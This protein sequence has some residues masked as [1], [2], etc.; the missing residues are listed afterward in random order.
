MKP[1]ITS[2]LL[3]LL[4]FVLKIRYCL[5]DLDGI[6]SGNEC[7]WCLT[8]H[9]IQRKTGTSWNS[10]ISS[11]W[12]G[13]DYKGFKS[14]KLAEFF[15][16]KWKRPGILSRKFCLCFYEYLI[17]G[18]ILHYFSFLMLLHYQLIYLCFDNDV[19]P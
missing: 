19:G 17:V 13:N 1:F 4:V 3:F 16:F 10:W 12:K 11:E 18:C 15:F 9:I 7:I 6:K 2:R 8:V 14:N 5:L